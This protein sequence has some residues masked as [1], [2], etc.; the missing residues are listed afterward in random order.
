MLVHALNLALSF[1]GAINP[2]EPIGSSDPCNWYFLNVLLDT[3]MGV[4]IVWLALRGMNYVAWRL[5]V[6]GVQMGNY[7]RPPRIQ[8][9][10]KQSMIYF[11]ALVTMKLSVWIIFQIMPWLEVVAG[12]LLSWTRG[13]PRIEVVLVLCIFPLIMNIMQYYILDT[14]IKAK[15]D[16]WEALD[17]EEEIDDVLSSDSLNMTGSGLLD[18]RPGSDGILAVDD[19]TS[20]PVSPLQPG[21]SIVKVAKASSKDA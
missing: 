18:R 1:V 6:E 20:E 4:G 19:P 12:F 11:A 2:D 10:L 7:G 15:D 8:W 14:I 16:T 21:V 3:T 9:W 17:S 5:G 13:H